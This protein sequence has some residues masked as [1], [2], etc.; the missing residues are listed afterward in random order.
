MLQLAREFPSGIFFSN[1]FGDKSP[2]RWDPVQGPKSIHIRRQT[3]EGWV[4]FSL[5]LPG[6]PDAKYRS[7]VTQGLLPL[8]GGPSSSR[9][10][11]KPT[12]WWNKLWFD[13]NQIQQVYGKSSIYA[14]TRAGAW[15]PPYEPSPALRGRVSR[16]PRIKWTRSRSGTRRIDVYR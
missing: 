7:R 13:S 10:D 9:S 14:S 4:C 3:L 2:P 1:G 15:G 6:L 16:P 11:S 8:L 12:G 5:S